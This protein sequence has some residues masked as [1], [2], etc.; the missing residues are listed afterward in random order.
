M[1]IIFS[2]CGELEKEHGVLLLLSAGISQWA[3]LSTFANVI[4]LIYLTLRASATQQLSQL[5]GPLDSTCLLSPTHCQCQ[6]CW[7]LFKTA[8]RGVALV[9]V[10]HINCNGY[11]TKFLVNNL[12]RNRTGNSRF[13]KQWLPQNQK[14]K[15]KQ[16]TSNKMNKTSIPSQCCEVC[17]FVC[18]CAC[19]LLLCVF[20]ITMSLCSV[21]VWVF[22]TTKPFATKLG[23]VV[24]PYS[25]KP[26]CHYIINYYNPWEEW[27]DLQC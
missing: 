9:M 20:L 10:G 26:K 16:K 5:H 1:G 6:N 3:L 23:M 19:V 15:T 17:V 12:N 21:F 27:F 13:S 8:N 4:V 22:W 7:Q 18:A 14:N 11:I 2:G 24:H 25:H